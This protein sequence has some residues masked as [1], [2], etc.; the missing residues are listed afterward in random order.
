[1]QSVWKFS[2]S[3][4]SQSNKIIFIG[5][6]LPETDLYVKYLLICGIKDCYNLNKIIVVCPDEQNKIQPRY[7]K[8][9]DINF[10]NKAFEFIP[11]TFEEWLGKTKKKNKSIS[12]LT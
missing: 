7:E 4:L 11:Q 12:F 2:H 3:L 8:F 5:Y 9:F 1:M 10:R 6:S